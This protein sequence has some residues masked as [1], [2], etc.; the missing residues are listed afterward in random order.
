[1]DKMKLRWAIAALAVAAAAGALTAGAGS[2]PTP[3]P[4]S[5]DGKIAYTSTWD[6]Q[7]DVYSID[8]KTVLNLTHDKTI[9]LRTDVQ[10]VWSPTGDYIAFER[11]YTK[12]GAD[13]MV[14]R[15]DGTQPVHSLLPGVSR[16]I[17]NC[18]PS[19][20][21]GNVVYFTSNR[22]GNFDLYAVSANSTK[23]LQLTTTTAPV[24]N[25]GPAVSPDG[26]T[27]AFFRTGL[28]W[29]VAQLHLLDVATGKTTQ[30]TGNL[31]GA[32]D[33][34]PAW[35]PDGSRLAFT[36]DRMGSQDIWLVHADGTGLVQVTYGGSSE[37]HPAFSPNGRQIAYV[38]DAT[39]ATEL[40]TTE[41]PT[42]AMTFVRPP[43]Q[44]TFDGAYKANPSWLSAT[45]N[46]TR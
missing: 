21:R 38:S 18:H 37:T 23:V 8:A 32:G 19:W 17:W 2:V 24:Q 13:L 3:A 46:A 30:L 5:I 7:A 26:R 43:T 36:S 9:G 20:S 22:D 45:P 39:G 15:A 40:F 6:G 12:G 31:R 41:T 44:I 1:V 10:P 11:Q 25:L 34:D 42:T 33:T 14:V 28:P 27:V 29:G 4:V 35:A 16:D